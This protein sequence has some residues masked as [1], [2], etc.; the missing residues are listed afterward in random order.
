M[1]K[2]TKFWRCVN[3]AE[4][5]I[6]LSSIFYWLWSLQLVSTLDEGG[7]LYFTKMRQALFIQEV[8]SFSS[9]NMNSLLQHQSM[10]FQIHVFFNMFRTEEKYYFPWSDVTRFESFK[11][12]FISVWYVLCS[13]HCSSIVL[14]HFCQNTLQTAKWRVKEAN[15]TLHR[16]RLP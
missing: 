4:T 12:P 1:S 11:R 6:Y 3:S 15:K 5:F 16:G 8:Q 7:F 10:S 13:E 2:K 9:G 14:T